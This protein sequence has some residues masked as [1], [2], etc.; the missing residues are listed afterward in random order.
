MCPIQ[1]QTD[2]IFLDFLVAYCKAK[3]KSSGD[4]ASPSAEVKATLNFTFSPTRSYHRVVVPYRDNFYET[5]YTWL[6]L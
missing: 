6:V 3:L 1:F 2:L 5:E 4:K